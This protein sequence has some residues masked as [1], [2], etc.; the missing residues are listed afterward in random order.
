MH[1]SFHD[2]Q[3]KEIDQNFRSNPGQVLRFWPDDRETKIGRFFTA[4]LGLGWDSPYI[5]SYDDRRQFSIAKWPWFD[6]NSH[7][8]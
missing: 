5:F 4:G 6:S 3:R 7:F 8:I 2:S 1:R